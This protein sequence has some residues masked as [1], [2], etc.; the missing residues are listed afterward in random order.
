MKRIQYHRYGGPEELRLEE[1]PLPVAGPNQIRVGIEAA[2]VNPLDWKMRKGE[3]KLMTGGKF[4][5]GLG[6]DFAGVVE[7][8][9]AQGHAIRSG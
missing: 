7:Y 6:H 8:R 1:F 2:A 4:P 9:S 5:R 3:M